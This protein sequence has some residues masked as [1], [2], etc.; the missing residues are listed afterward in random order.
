MENPDN[1]P[2]KGM[3]KSKKTAVG[4]IIGSIMLVCACG[5]VI[6]TLVCA[7]A[8]YFA[9]TFRNT[10]T[11]GIEVDYPKTVQVGDSFE[12]TLT[13]NN[14]GEADIR[15]QDIDLSPAVNGNIDSILAGATV[16]RTEPA[17]ES[18]EVSLVKMRDYHYDRVMKP[19]E[20][21]QVIFYFQAVKAGGFDTDI[22][23]YLSDSHTTASD[24]RISIIP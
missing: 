17:M 13:L 7:V 5:I 14:K 2:R 10:D 4:C 3:S 9:Y 19:G 16:T 24:I 20:T 11:L 6:L 22:D 23:F 15:V 18:Y 12:L 1:A 8:G 21:Q